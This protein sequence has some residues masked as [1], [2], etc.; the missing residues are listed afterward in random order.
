MADAQAR[1]VR[2]RET[3]PAALER[4]CVAQ[5]LY[6]HEPGESLAYP[7]S[8]SGGDAR[9]LGARYLEC[10]LVQAA[11]LRWQ[12]PD[13]QL[14]LVTNL[15]SR[16]WL[17]RRGR[18]LLDRILALGVE[19]VTADYRHA[20]RR[21]AEVFY[22]SC[23]VF[24]A[25]DA[26]TAGVD[27]RRRLWFV[28]VDCV[29]VDPKAAFEADAAAAGS[30]IGTVQIGYPP[31]WPM[32]GYTR[33]DLGTLG[34]RLG[35]CVPVPTW[36]GG[37]VLAGT[38]GELRRLVAVCEDL[39]REL[40]GIDGS[41]NTEEQLLS[42][43]GGLG[44]L[45]FR[46]L[47]GVAG[48]IWTGRRHEASNPPNPAA[49][50]LWHIPSEKG[51]SIRRAANA[52]LRGRT[53]RLRRDLSSRSRAAARFNVSGVRWSRSMRDDTWIAGSRVRDAVALRTGRG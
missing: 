13:C 22:S 36:I 16:E 51:L 28:D 40:E 19:L 45:E 8:R 39:D 30:G 7:S 29:W 52:L 1:I 17:T 34:G 35:A 53:A 20:P 11:S 33:E 26:V 50:A 27:P 42:L 48:R 3:T 6:L 32:R 10:V 41:L 47:S 23:F 25:I 37:E 18:A 15:P 12:A 46:S 43:A 14:L 31:D 38:A 24:D 2:E 4:P 21:P 9:S 49:L 44:R 5:Y